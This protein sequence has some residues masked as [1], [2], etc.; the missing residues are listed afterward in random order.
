MA[1]AA[2]S[3]SIAH[4]DVV[5]DWHAASNTLVLLSVPDEAALFRLRARAAADGL[6]C[7]G[8]HEPDLDHALTALALEPAARRLVRRL[9][10]ALHPSP[11]STD[12]PRLAKVHS[13]GR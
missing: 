13:G 3:F 1:H 5:R 2:F 12:P 10:L 7:L 9:R 11:S 8:F 6:R 4:P